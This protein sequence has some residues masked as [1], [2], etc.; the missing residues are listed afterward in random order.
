MTRAQAIAF[1]M[2][3]ALMVIMMLTVVG[4]S[5]AAA[6]SAPSPTVSVEPVPE[7]TV[8]HRLARV[9]QL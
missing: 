4:E 2:A 5:D 6:P 7:T 3:F 9:Q 8:V 1:W